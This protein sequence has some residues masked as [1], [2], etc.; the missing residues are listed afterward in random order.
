MRIVNFRTFLY[1]AVTVLIGVFVCTLYLINHI[2]GIVLFCL[3]LAANIVLFVLYFKKFKYA[4][5]FA[6]SI[7]S[8]ASMF[9]ITAVN[10]IDHHANID[11]TAQHFIS[12]HV[13]S[14]QREAGEYYIIID[15]VTI[16][17]KQIKGKMRIHAEASSQDKLE[18]LD[19]GDCISLSAQIYKIDT[20][21]DGFLNTYS[22]SSDIRYSVYTESAEISYEIDSV[23]ILSKFRAFVQRTLVD[24]MGE[25]Y[26]NLA[27]GMLSG[28]RSGIDPETSTYFGIAGLGHILAVSGLHVGFI[29]SL[30]M[31]AMRRLSPKIKV[32]IATAFVALYATFA[33]FSFSVIRAALMS[34]IGLTTLIN[35]QRSDLLNNMSAAFALIL[36]VSPFALFDAGFSMSFC[37]V[38]GIACFDKKFARIL[39]KCKFPRFIASAVAISLS[40]QIGVLPCVMYFF[41]S[42]PLYSAIA[43]ILLMPLITLIFIV[44][45]I[46]CAIS[47][48]FSFGAL[49]VVPQSMLILLDGA[50]RFIADLPLAQ[51]TVFVDSSIFLLI[52]LYFIISGFVMLPKIKRQIS[53]CALVCCMTVC[54]VSIINF[55]MDSAIVPVRAYNDVTSI[56]RTDGKTLIVGDCRNGKQI[57]RTLNSDRLGKADAVYLTSLDSSTADAVIY[58]DSHGICDTFYCPSDA[59]TDAVYYL[60]DNDIDIK[61][62]DTDSSPENITAEYSDGKFIGY[63][64]KCV[65]D[66][67]TL[68]LGAK[69]LLKDIDRK[70]LNRTAI[71]RCR[72]FTGYPD[73]RIYLTNFTVDSIDASGTFVYPV[74]E[75][76]DYVF[77]Y[78]TGKVYTRDNEQA[79]EAPD[80]PST[81]TEQKKFFVF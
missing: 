47:A 32:P 43:N 7:I 27:Y 10:D 23:G 3:H 61:V 1:C 71:I 21:Q 26:G 62:F 55:G 11:Y 20:L 44:L 35:G 18:F 29:I 4:V 40:A 79:T 45:F 75:I 78:M 30:L 65:K 41:H 39:L 48:V 31:F 17:D 34:T 36:S 2:A 77:D 13:Y 54:G 67:N 72:L 14:T 76:G 33:G 68:F 51:P 66:Y 74:T 8:L 50:A 15:K 37:A 5:A 57:I 53:L 24:F 58:L 42:L 12:G 22:I 52:P 63:S 16:D 19:E 60:I 80:T 64:L 46:T 56:I 25:H 6:L 69:T 49:L 70:I 73:D 38:F 81:M 9:A 59:L 28:D